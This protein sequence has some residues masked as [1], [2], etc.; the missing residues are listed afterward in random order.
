MAGL[1]YRNRITSVC[2]PLRPDKQI[3]QVR[4]TVNEISSGQYRKEH[5]WL[6]AVV[7]YYNIEDVR[8]KC[9]APRI[10]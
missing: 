2:F 8:E 3:N 4:L 10:N 7:A 5:M 1:N 6:L 9:R